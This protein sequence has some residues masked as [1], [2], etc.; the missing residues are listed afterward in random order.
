MKS[1][2]NLIMFCIC[3]LFV[4]IIAMKKTEKLDKEFIFSP[5]FI[6]ANLG[7]FKKVVYYISSNNMPFSEKLIVSRS[8]LSYNKGD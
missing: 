4:N 5:N 6:E 2:K 3:S 1:L 7:R 8:I